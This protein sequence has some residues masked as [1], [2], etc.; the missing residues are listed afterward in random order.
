[1]A[2]RGWRAWGETTDPV[3]H[4]LLLHRDF[5]PALGRR[6]GRKTRQAVGQD[7]QQGEVSASSACSHH[8]TM[9]TTFL[10]LPPPPHCSLIDTFLTCF[11]TK[12]LPANTHKYTPLLSFQSPLKIPFIANVVQYK[13]GED[14]WFAFSETERSSSK[15]N[16]MFFWGCDHLFSG[17]GMGPTEKE[18]ALWW[19]ANTNKNPYAIALLNAGN[20][21][22]FYK[23][24]VFYQH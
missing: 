13:A 22:H 18:P 8:Q 12:A 1:M 6:I 4:D 7:C 17:A 23:S 11:Y 21:C 10:V 2:R 20:F 3:W 24:V 16:P 5:Y 19:Y 14:L 15:K 9:R